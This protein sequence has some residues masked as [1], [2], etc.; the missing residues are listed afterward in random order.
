MLSSW[1]SKSGNDIS[2]R[3]MSP[4][5]FFVIDF[6]LRRMRLLVEHWMLAVLYTHILLPARNLLLERENQADDCI[7]SCDDDLTQH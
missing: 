6:H 1:D 5:P 2:N 3:E 4:E 7:Y